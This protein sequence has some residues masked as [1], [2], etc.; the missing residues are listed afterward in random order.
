MSSVVEGKNDG[1]R[2][3][4][5]LVVT[6]SAF[7]VALDTTIVNIAIPQLQ[8]AFKVDVAAAQWIVTTYMLA[9]GAI[10]PLSSFLANRIGIRRSFLVA[11]GV[12]TAG[13]ALCSLAPTLGFLVASRVVLALGGGPVLTLAITYVLRAYPPDNRATAIATVQVPALFAPMLG[14]VVGGLIISVASWRYVFLINVPIG[15]AALVLGIIFLPEHPVDSRG[16]FD[17]LGF[18]TVAPGFVALLFGLSQGAKIGWGSPVVLATLAVGAALLVFFVLWELN[19]ARA[20]RAPL[21]DLRL[22]RLRSFWA[23]V[24]AL[25]LLGCVLFWPN[26]IMPIYLQ[27]LRAM[28]PA[29]SGLV[30]ASLALG[31]MVFAL[32]GGLIADRIGTK[33]V[34]L[35]GV[36]ALAVVSWLF[37]RITLATPVWQIAVLLGARGMCSGLSLQ[38][39]FAAAMIDVRDPAEVA[40]GSTLTT[41]IR[42]VGGAVGTGLL[43][44][45]AQMWAG[46]FLRTAS[47]GSQATTQIRAQAQI[48]GIQDTVLLSAAVTIVAIGFVFVLRNKGKTAEAGR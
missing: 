46:S 29:H 35:I 12:F 32:I 34:S 28:S 19:V 23:G 20:G 5:V 45:L 25:A 36:C 27:S 1:R 15:L 47:A 22:F 11:L 10:T 8:K 38:P 41:M 9:V 33:T 31:S 7:M 42:N 48:V 17:V 14:P 44:S 13:S 40:H 30:M 4:T 24:T 37:S 3:L 18:V 16:R 26:F 2:W 39:L 21:L 43:V 6:V